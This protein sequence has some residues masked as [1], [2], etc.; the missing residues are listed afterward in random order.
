M[1]GS[2]IRD[3]PAAMALVLMLEAKPEKAEVW[4]RRIPRTE[5]GKLNVALED[6]SMQLSRLGN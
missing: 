3:Y 4:L 1:I 5:R 2:H 6:L